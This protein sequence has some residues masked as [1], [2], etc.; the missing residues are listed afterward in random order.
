MSGCCCCCPTKLLV[1]GAVSFCCCCCCLSLSACASSGSC[2]SVCVM[3]AYCLFLLLLLQQKQIDWLVNPSI[4]SSQSIGGS[5]FALSL[6]FFPSLPFSTMS[7]LSELLPALPLSPSIACEP[8]LVNYLLLIINR[9]LLH[10]S[11]FWLQ[12][13]GDGGQCSHHH[14][15]HSLSAAIYHCC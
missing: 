3:Q 9:L 2:Y 7:V 13:G 14:C 12:S 6:S 5:D 1:Y 11:Q 15:L 8:S 10:S 4:F